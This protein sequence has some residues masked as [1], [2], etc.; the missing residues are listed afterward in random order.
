MSRKLKVNV[1]AKPN[2]RLSYIEEP[3][4]LESSNA[5]R[6]IFGLT[7]EIITGLKQGLTTYAYA[8]L[9][10]FS[11]AQFVIDNNLPPKFDNDNGTGVFTSR[12]DQYKIRALQEYDKS[13]VRNLDFTR[14]TNEIRVTDGR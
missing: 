12:G 10:D 14:D 2:G 3:A 9:E 13:W 4:V 11:V 8:D 7:V 5:R 6:L 1:N